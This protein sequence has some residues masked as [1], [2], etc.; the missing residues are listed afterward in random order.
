MSDVQA[1]EYDNIVG[2]ALDVSRFSLLHLRYQ[3]AKAI[4]CGV[5]KSVAA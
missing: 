2:N 4:G 1:A 5:N 3:V